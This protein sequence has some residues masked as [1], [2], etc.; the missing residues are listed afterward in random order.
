MEQLTKIKILTPNL[1]FTIEKPINNYFDFI[2]IS[3]VNIL[4]SNNL[5]KY[6]TN[7][8]VTLV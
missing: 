7:T 5:L 1:D 6:N 8:P 3:K 2:G 4:F